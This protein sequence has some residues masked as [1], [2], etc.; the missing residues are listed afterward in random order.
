MEDFYVFGYG[1]RFNILHWRRSTCTITCKPS[2]GVGTRLVHCPFALKGL[3]IA[4]DMD[5][6]GSLLIVSI[7]L[8]VNNFFEMNSVCF[9]IKR[10]IYGQPL[11][12]FQPRP[13]Y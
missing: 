10:A 12:S 3:V 8:F 2:A 7:I 4:Y 13:S 11:L 1:S 9:M 5:M 6:H